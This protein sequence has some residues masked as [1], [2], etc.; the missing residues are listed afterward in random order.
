MPTG[1]E[2]IYIGLLPQLATCDIVGHAKNLGLNTNDDGSVSIN[3]LTH[4]Y[5]ITNQGVEQ[6]DGR[7]P[8]HINDRSLVIHYILSEGGIEPKL[9]FVPIGRLSGVMEGHDDE[10]WF[11][12]D[13]LLRESKGKYDV[14]A[15]AAEAMGGTYE[16]KLMSGHSWQFL[17]FPK[18][19]MRLLYFEP[20][21]EFPAEVQ[22]QYDETAPFYMDFECLAFLS[23]SLGRGLCEI[24]Q[25]Q[26]AER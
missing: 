12:C 13:A 7:D 11:I 6:V 25:Q 4:R 26:K 24:I 23:T 18:M 17:V 20:D 22:V 16:G 9:S 21:E 15:A 5:L 1:Y 14:F 2:Q 19:P 3:F 8:V 10:N